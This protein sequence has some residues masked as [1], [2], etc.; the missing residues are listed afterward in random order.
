MFAFDGNLG[1][2]GLRP[3]VR[4]IDRTHPHRLGTALKNTMDTDNGPQAEK[5]DSSQVTSHLVQTMMQHHPTYQRAEA[6]S[7]P[8]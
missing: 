5:D 1:S 3:S 2:T 7:P 8:S 6:K 4:S